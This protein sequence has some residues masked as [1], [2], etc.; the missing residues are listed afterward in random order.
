MQHSEEG[1]ALIK[2]ELILKNVC[3]RA[4]VGENNLLFIVLTISVSD[5]A[6][7]YGNKF[8]SNLKAFLNINWQEEVV[9]FSY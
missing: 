3:R 1:A 5:A 4:G 8:M 2:I 9:L 7:F 6:T